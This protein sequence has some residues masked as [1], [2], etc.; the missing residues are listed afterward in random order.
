MA[1]LKMG[2]LFAEVS[3]S[4]GQLVFSKWKGL[5]YARYKAATI[6]NPMSAH[7]AQVRNCLATSTQL[8]WTLTD[9][10][11]AKWEEYA[12]G[13][14]KAGADQKAVGTKCL[15]KPR[16]VLQSG[17]NAFIGANLITDSID[18]PRVVI[19]STLAKPPGILVE[20]HLG[21]EDYCAPQVGP[22]ETF[23]IQVDITPLSVCYQ[24]T[25]ARVWMSGVWA[26]SH[27]YI[28]GVSAKWAVGEDDKKT[29]TITT[30][31]MGSNGNMEEVPLEHC[32]YI[33]LQVDLADVMAETG[34][35]SV[36]PVT[37]CLSVA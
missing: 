17:Y 6:M 28:G 31:R 26:G 33:K 16:G 24:D 11:R 23:S 9:I 37:H 32:M 1:K 22:P 10:Q 18:Q 2:A 15:I 34:P 7:Q 30:I 35:P 27:A 13:Q 19:P 29:V 14:G 25:Y 4:I 12:Q 36:C 20:K 8:W 5:P 3:G 21:L